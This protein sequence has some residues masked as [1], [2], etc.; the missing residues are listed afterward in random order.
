MTNEPQTQPTPPPAQPVRRAWKPHPGPQ[1]F[2]LR[3]DGVFETLYGGA[4]GGGK[5]ESGEAWLVRPPHFGNPLYRALVVRRN[6]E[7]LC[8]WMDRAGRMYRDIGGHILS[9]APARV[10]F[11]NGAVFRLGHLKDKEAYSKYQGH[12]YQRM[13]I[14]E[15]QQ[16]KEESSYEQLLGSCR[17]TV[18]GL[19]AEVML[20][21]NPGGM[22][23]R[24]LKARF[25]TGKDD[26]RK[27]CVAYP[28]KDGRLRMYVPS[29]VTDNPSLMDNDPAYI[30]WLEGLP[31]PLRSAWRY[32]DWDI[33][34]GQAFEWSSANI[35]D[36]CPIPVNA[37][38]LMTFDWGFGKPFSVG[39]WW[40]LSEGILIRVGEWYG[41]EPGRANM[42]LRLADH[43]IAA[44]ILKREAELGLADKVHVRLADPTVFNRKPDSTG[45]GL[46][47][48]TAT[49]FQRC[50]VSLRP[51]DANRKQKFRQFAA[52][53]KSRSLLV[54]RTCRQFIRTVPELPLDENS[55]DDVD[56]DSEDHVYDEA[57]HACMD[58]PM[59]GE[60]L[61]GTALDGKVVLSKSTF[62]DPVSS[63]RRSGTL[64][65]VLRRANGYE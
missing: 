32:G 10:E 37:R 3:V 13:L 18:P 2:M 63:Y 56:T 6:F 31:E 45:G 54:F 57:C 21:A 42:G 25:G 19:A 41:C 33:Y 11:A 17:S 55:F 9:G 4:R 1:T 24:W 49:I 30:A 5:T 7:D 38:L 44:G 22:G 29:K 14:E 43:E 48:S 16:I 59:P 34:S 47:D 26:P 40:V 15:A 50:G 39:W 65:D 64:A 51:G 12:E 53:I 35:V 52:R 46:A 58:V 20:T 28:G 36:P 62:D 61:R 23:H 60:A 27:P 8:D